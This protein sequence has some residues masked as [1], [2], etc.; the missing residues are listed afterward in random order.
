MNIREHVEIDLESEPMLGHWDVSDAVSQCE[1]QFGRRL[2][3]VQHPKNESPDKFV[4][5][6]QRQISE[7][8]LDID[9]AVAFAERLTRTMLPEFWEAHDRST[10]SGRRLDVYSLHFDLVPKFPRYTI[11]KSHDFDYT[12]VRYEEHDLWKADSIQEVLPEPP[13]DLWLSVRRL[14]SGEFENAV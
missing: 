14:G 7:V 8:W 10:R 2:I 3:Y 9:N 11:S 5:A 6:A 1:F 13:D 4:Q 12:F